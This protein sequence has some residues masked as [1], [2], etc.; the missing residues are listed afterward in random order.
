MLGFILFSQILSG[1]LLSL[2]YFPDREKAFAR[3]AHIERDVNYG[4]WWRGVHANGARLMMLFIYIHI[5]RGL[6]FDSYSTY[7][8]L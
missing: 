1:F 7:L 3:V 6:Y 8:R 2:H 5:G 4:W